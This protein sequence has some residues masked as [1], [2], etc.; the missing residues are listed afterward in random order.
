M[1]RRLRELPCNERPQERLSKF[2]AKSLS[3]TELL[4]LII[5]SGTRKKDVLSLAG[6]VIH[7]AGSLAGLLRGLLIDF[8]LKLTE[9]EK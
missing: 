1:N 5:R 4:A 2:G 8:L 6:E 3:D 7:D 9:S